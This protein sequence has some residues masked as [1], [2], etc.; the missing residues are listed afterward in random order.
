MNQDKSDLDHLH[1]F[2]VLVYEAFIFIILGLI[3]SSVGR[4]IC[5][6]EIYAMFSYVGT[7]HFILSFLVN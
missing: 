5:L 1:F 3:C 4:F 6:I 7:R 2:I